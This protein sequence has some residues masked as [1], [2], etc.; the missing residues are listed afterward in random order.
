MT[1]NEEYAAP[2][3][4]YFD[5]FLTDPTAKRAWKECYT[6]VPAYISKRLSLHSR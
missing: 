2:G 6:F 3:R 4:Q 1:K 5:A